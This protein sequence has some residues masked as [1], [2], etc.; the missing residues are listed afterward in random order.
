MVVN[1]KIIQDVEDPSKNQPGR[2]NDKKE[3]KFFLASDSIFK[4]IKDLHNSGVMDALEVKR[5]R[6][7]SLREVW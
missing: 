4:E 5:Q 7:D 6:I 2:D 1:A 3:M